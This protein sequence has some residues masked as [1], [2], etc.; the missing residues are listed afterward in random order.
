MRLRAI[1]SRIILRWHQKALQ[2]RLYPIFQVLQQLNALQLTLQF[3]GFTIWAGEIVYTSFHRT[4]A[5]GHYVLFF[6]IVTDL[7]M[8]LYLTKKILDRQ[9][10]AFKA[11][12]NKEV[13]K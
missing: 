2:K 3:T 9:G 7:E 8:L 13:G 6:T 4:C 1:S 12:R 5:A 10:C 11:L